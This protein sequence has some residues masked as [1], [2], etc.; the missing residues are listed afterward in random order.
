VS[1][2]KR[3]EV[4]FI[5]LWGIL[6]GFNHVSAAALSSC[7]RMHQGRPTL[8]INDE[9]WVPLMYA[10]TDVP[11]GRW[12][13][14]EVPQRN[15]RLF[16]EAGVRLFQ[17]DLFLEHVWLEQGRFDLSRARQQIR[18]VLQVCPQAAVFIR[19]HVNAPRWWA[20]QHPE[21]TTLYA[22]AKAKPDD[23]WGL[24]RIIQEDAATP[25]R[26]SL[27]SE[28]WLQACGEK[29]EQFCRELAATE[30][31]ARVAGLQAAGGIYGEW[32]YWGLLK[33]EPD[34]SE[35]MQAHFR[36][37][38]RNKY[39]SDP[40][41]QKAWGHTQVT[42]ADARV[43]LLEE[44]LQTRDGI[45]RDPRTEPN[46]LDYYRCQHEL[47]A[48]DILYFCRLMR[49]SWPRPLALGAFY[50]YYFSVFGREAAGGHLALQRI[51][52]SPDIDFLC[53]PNVY[54]PAHTEVGDPYRSRGLL[55]S[56]RLH[57]KLWLDEMDQQPYLKSVLDPG[58]A[59]GVVNSVAHVRRNTLFSFTKGMGLW[60]Y[61]FGAAGQRLNSTAAEFVTGWWD[62]PVLMK[63]IA[64]LKRFLDQAWKKPYR[65]E[66]DV[67]MVF[68][69]DCYYHTAI[70]P[71]LNPIGDRVVNWTT[72]AA[73]QAGAVF[74]A[75]HQDDLARC[76]LDQYKLVV[77]VNT[78][79]VSAEQR[80]WIRE[81]VFRRG[82]H[83]MFL[84]ASGYSDGESNSV[85]FIEQLT[86]IR[87]A[88]AAST[89]AP[90]IRTTFS[91]TPW[92]LEDKP[93]A[94]VFTIT[95]DEAT[96]LAEY[97][98]SGE[99]AA[100]KKTVAD[101]TSWIIGL[102]PVEKDHVRRLFES[103]GV[104]F[105]AEPGD[106]FYSGGGALVLHSKTGGR[107]NIVLK[108]GR[109]VSLTLPPGANTVVLDSDSGELLLP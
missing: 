77:F 27:A 1:L 90:E 61:D 15:I 39:G 99:T 75:L 96:P 55:E 88:R 47:V 49:K 19:F 89:Q 92:I 40:A 84:Y 58:Y 23:S 56:I 30:E 101:A 31:G 18:G 69:T 17:V 32:H 22:D 57:G 10:L 6:M 33:N 64:G 62:H 83:V 70:K 65:S 73:Y 54:Y 85:E 45:F 48:D 29:V 37:W 11:G 100:A 109:S 97:V 50:G 51:L 53:G 108:N 107:K 14:E 72:L 74:D 9:P 5:F 106:I 36:R 79:V 94:P 59:D 104:H 93:F 95:D 2:M 24:Q 71:E 12:S 81:H 91:S 102:P 68:G 44:R 67:L 80:R 103:C 63:E 26:I 13:W 38:L 105:Y 78:F 60:F 41:L 3:I 42:L 52:N 87:V 66:A 7:V 4:S 20:A 86:G 35:P 21:E 25:V 28:K 82:R 98:E 8:F 34:I 16:A 43:P 46:L 76:N